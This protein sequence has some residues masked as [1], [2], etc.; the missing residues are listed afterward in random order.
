MSK[1]LL[2][3]C[4][5]VDNVLMLV[6]E[7][8]DEDRALAEAEGMVGEAMELEDTYDFTDEW[9]AEKIG[10]YRPYVG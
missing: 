3:T 6:P 1:L 10:Y 8:W 5:L 4:E 2:Y 7:D 9:L